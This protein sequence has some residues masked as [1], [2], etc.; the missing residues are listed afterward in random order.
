M[1]SLSRIGASVALLFVASLSF[2]QSSRPTRHV[3]VHAA[4][5]GACNF[6]LS[7][8]FGGRVIDNPSGDAPVYAAYLATYPSCFFG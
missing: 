8:S 5:M 3:V 1:V 2:A 4:N 6:R 7:N